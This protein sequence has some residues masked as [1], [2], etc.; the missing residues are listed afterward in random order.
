MGASP[1]RA[2]HL[3]IA[4]DDW[5]YSDRYNAGILEAAR[6]AAIDAV[7]AMVLRRACDP[8]PLIESGV[9]IG[10]HVEVP[11]AAGQTELL[12]APWRQADAFERAFGRQPA[13]LDGHHHCHARPPLATAVEDLA[14]E[15]KVP[16]RATGED[17][18]LHLRDRGIAVADRLVGRIDEHEP[19]LPPLIAAAL[20]EGA[21]PPGTTEWVVHP[22][23]VDPTAGSNYDRGREQDLALLIELLGEETLTGGRATHRAALAAARS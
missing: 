18:R 4:A 10:L 2:G 23:H 9:E 21:L 15:L 20:Q 22:G 7:S 14:L 17:H 3:I 19:I 13:Y 12:E 6:A 11:G 8:D 5:G 1:D 16:V